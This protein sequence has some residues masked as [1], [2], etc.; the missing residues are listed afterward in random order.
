MQIF[1]HGVLLGILFICSLLS[2]QIMSK[3]P[4]RYCSIQMSEPDRSSWSDNFSLSCQLSSYPESFSVTS[5]VPV[6]M[7]DVARANINNSSF[8]QKRYLLSSIEANNLLRLQYAY[9]VAALLKL[10]HLTDYGT[11]ELWS[12][13]KDHCW[14]FWKVHECERELKQKLQERAVRREQQ[15]LQRTEEKKQQ[16]LLIKKQ[17]EQEARNQ[18]IYHTDLLGSDY[19]SPYYD[20]RKQALAKTQKDKCQKYEQCRE[21]DVQTIGLCMAKNI[22]YQ[23]LQQCAGTAIQHQLYDEV[24]D[25]YKKIAQFFCQPTLSQSI[26]AQQSLEFAQCVTQATELEAMELAIALSDLAHVCTETACS[27]I[28]GVND[29]LE[30][31]AD[32]IQDPFCAAKNLGCCLGRVMNYV[33]EAMAHADSESL[34]WIYY[35]QELE[36]EHQY[37]AEYAQQVVNGIK[38]WVIHSSAQN[39]VRMVTRC[40]AD[41]ILYGNLCKALSQAGKACC[42]LIADISELR[43]LGE[44]TDVYAE[45]GLVTE[46]GEVGLISLEKA[47]MSLMEFEVD[48]VRK[49]K[50][51]KETAKNAANRSTSESY[52]AKIA[53]LIKE[54][55]LQKYTHHLNTFSKNKDDVIHMFRNKVGKFADTIENRKIILKIARDKSKCFGIDNN[56]VLSYAQVDELGRQVWVEVNPLNYKIRN[57][58]FNDA[59]MHRVWSK[60]TGFKLPYRK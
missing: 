26:L 19:L 60:D 12:L 52:W 46:L 17:K 56:G 4:D 36:K 47:G 53:K 27:I 50:L 14:K 59:G 37:D 40:I 1:K 28:A 41:G 35:A 39:K 8:C 48:T 13:Y 21:L 30:G 16:Q 15:R 9:I 23:K 24:A 32:V 33:A 6:S 54:F 18:E 44:F 31:I 29:A 25:C 45:Y 2:E 58:G 22:D 7:L 3:A 5:Y 55:D 51:V 43:F 42:G 49:T 20:V 11:Y 38:S 10:D 34:G 57:C